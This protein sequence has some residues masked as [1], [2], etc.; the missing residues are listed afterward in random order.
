MSGH[1]EAALAIVNPDYEC[2]A[3]IGRGQPATARV[4]LSDL[5]ASMPLHCNEWLRRST[6]TAPMLALVT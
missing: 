3:Q 6:L 4:A 5:A 1:G 2:A